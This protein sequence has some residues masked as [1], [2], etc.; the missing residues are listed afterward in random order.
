M[1]DDNRPV[2]TRASA[3]RKWKINNR[4]GRGDRSPL[5]VWFWELD[6][7]LLTLIGVLIAIG[8]IAVAAASPVAAMKHSTVD[9]TLNPLYYFYRQL[10][11][12]SVGIPVMLVISMLP[13]EQARR[14][15]IISMIIM[16]VLLFLV[17]IMGKTVN[18]AQRWI[19]YGFATIQPAEFLKPF[20]AVSLAWILS[21]R[22]K[23]STLPTIPLSIVLTGI[24][25]ILLMNQPDLG[26][27]IIFCGIW[28]ALMMLAG[29]STRIIGL[30]FLG[31]IGGMVAA[32]FFYPVA[33]QRI[34]VWLFGG[35]S[36]DQ[37]MLAHKTLVGGGLIGTGPGLGVQK[38]RLP[39]AHTDYIFSVIG[40]EFGLLACIAIALVYLA[41]IVRV[42]LRLLDEEDNFVILAVAGLVAQFGG[43]A[44]INMA[45][46]LQLFPSKGM[47]LPFISYGGSS[48]IAL[49]FGIG[50]LLALTRRNPYLDRSPYV[51]KWND[52]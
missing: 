35:E 13:R 51:V 26:Q 1:S 39:E 5:G 16:L 33:T 6:R 32:Y 27:T 22:I 43:Q 21:W 7:V 37:I 30:T 34:N 38:F 24:I 36:H 46:N 19:G 12:V 48:I 25:V 2:E 40:E 23:D 20:F 14:F 52:K 9:I 29:L 18:G 28:F 17:P 11:W 42:F 50:L 47:T 44:I 4:L 49:S 8:L 15:A 3:D 41:I 45:V 10:F 31:G